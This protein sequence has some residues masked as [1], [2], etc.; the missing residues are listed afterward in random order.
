MATTVV[1]MKQ[2]LC[3]LFLLNGI[4]EIKSELTI[5][6]GAIVQTSKGP[7]QGIVMTTPEGRDFNAFLG[8]PFGKP[9]LG[10]LRYK[11]SRNSTCDLLNIQEI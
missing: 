7:V 9:P 5:E 4:I 6:D 3:F 1:N 11:V 10:E 8:I 2:L